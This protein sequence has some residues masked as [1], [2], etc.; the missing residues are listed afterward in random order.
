VTTRW[1][2]ERAWVGDQMT[3]HVSISCDSHGIITDVSTQAEHGGASTLR[4]LVLPGFANTHSHAFHRALR[5]RGQQEGSFWQ[6]REQMYRL[7]NRL[8]PDSYLGL[9][10]AV[11][12][13]MVLAGFTVVGEFH[14]LHHRPDGRQYDDANEMGEV[15]MEA[16][17]LAGIRLT[18]LDTCFVAG[19]IGE[20]VQPEQ[21]RFSDGDVARW[22]VR[23]A[24]LEEDST[25]RIGA[26]IHSVR[27]VPADQIRS[28]VEAAREKPLHMHVSEQPA[29]NDQCYAAYGVTPTGL[30]AERGALGPNTT[31][32]HAT[33]LTSGD[34]GLLSSSK[35]AVC[36]CP[37]TERD[38]GDGIGP[39]LALARG[40]CRIAL[41]T[42]QHAVIDPFEEIRGLETHQRL[43]S[44]RRGLFG[45]NVLIEHA[46]AD[47]H[48]ALGWPDNG[49]IRVGSSCDLVAIDLNSVRTAG[50]DPSQAVMAATAADVRT[51]IAG[52]RVIVSDGEHQIGNVA[53]LLDGAVNAL[54]D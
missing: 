26:A 18:L 7:A 12:S 38:L 46:T 49:Q 21:A 17:K 42:D 54:W 52:G 39:A 29:E 51:V 1:W 9:A 10:T 50:A 48:R 32:I 53:R 27:S 20:P 16:A 22:A 37:T 14:Y 28:V 35:C 6:W 33:H 2:C 43:A 44:L 36:M 41:G 3:E 19:G 45:P 47:G 24:E 40:G 23:H 5:G 11:Y 25:T 15:L 13:E 4:G 34:I 30:L 8:D 31:A